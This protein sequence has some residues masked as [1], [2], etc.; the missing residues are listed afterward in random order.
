M[1]WLWRLLLKTGPAALRRRAVERMGR[2]PGDSIL[3]HLAAA[4]VDAD[5]GVRLALVRAMDSREGQ[6]VHRLL[7]GGLK[8]P[9]ADVR[10]C[11]AEQVTRRLLAAV[12]GSDVATLAGLLEAGADPNA[13][14]SEGQPL[15]VVSLKA[16]KG[17]EVEEVVSLLVR[18]GADPNQAGPKR[19]SPLELALGTGSAK[20]V[21]MLLGAKAD[22]DGRTASGL[23]PLRHAVNSGN[24]ELVR[25]LLAAGAKVELAEQQSLPLLITALKEI[26]DP[27]KEEIAG[28]LLGAGADPNRSDR[29]GLTP[30]EW[31]LRERRHGLVA[32]LLKAKADPNAQTSDGR[33][34][35]GWVAGSGAVET[36]RCLLEAGADPNERG[37]DGCPPL[38]AAIRDA[39]AK[40]RE[41]AVRA[42]LAAGADANR[43]DAEGVSPLEW[44]S[45]KDSQG[46]LLSMLLAAHANPNATTSDGL[47]PLIKA[48]AAGNW[49]AVQLLLG[50]GANPRVRDRNGRTLL[51]LATQSGSQKTVRLLL[52]SGAD[53]AQANAG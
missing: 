37:K 46:S 31:A 53:P 1:V 36:L 8:D 15:M 41:A 43:A 51:M 5:P 35:L 48:A 49:T 21:R 38:L 22:P 52:D 28:L 13:A 19:T 2:Q 18:A 40:E 11:A 17:Q 7:A 14:D 24:P 50:A 16:L 4:W 25:E 26:Q 33:T 30:L 6:E 45:A 44:A 32:M 9:D 34:P 23:Y 29:K 20:L 10:G 3:G 12:S 47:H 39:P 42:L 27:A